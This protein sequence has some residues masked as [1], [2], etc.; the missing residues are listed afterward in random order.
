V[1]RTNDQGTH[2][3]PSPNLYP[4]DWLWDAG[5]NAL[6][7][8]TFAEDRAWRELETILAGQWPTGMIPHIL[9]LASDPSYFPGP[10]EWGSGTDPATSG[11]TQPP[12]L[13]TVLARLLACSADQTTARHRARPLF[14]RLVSYHDWWHTSRDPDRTGLVI[15]I[16]PW[17]TGMDNSPAWDTALAAVE[18]TPL[19][20]DSRRDL[21][22][23]DPAD[24]P[25]D[26]D[27]DRYWSL[28]RD[29]RSVQWDSTRLAT[30]SSFRV[31]D[32]LTN[33]ILIRADT[34]LAHLARLLDAAPETITRLDDYAKLGSTG[35]ERLWDRPAE[36][37]RAFDFNRGILIGPATVASLCVPF[38]RVVPAERVA[39]LATQARAWGDSAGAA[40]PS[41]D[42]SFPGFDPARYWRGPVWVN[43]NWLAATGFAESG[44][45]ATAEYLADQTVSLITTAGFAEYF[46]PVTHTAHGSSAFSWTASLALAWL[47][48]A[49]L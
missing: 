4:A 13:A 8:A 7:W 18:P 44:H 20:S 19:P 34:D 27:Y 30:G 12:I 49:G 21:T 15:S 10:E 37:Y 35:L 40:L 38:S 9:F 28:L 11:I 16:H 43:T 17:E 3:V 14:D 6:G 48:P 2:T 24:R 46:N 32:P 39:H 31:A 47:A 26:Y 23:V 25:T 29:G 33:A 42:P 5:F 41:V 1:L 45:P 36:H 22:V